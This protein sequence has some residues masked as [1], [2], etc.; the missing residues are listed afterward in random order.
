MNNM[1]S[2]SKPVRVR[3][4]SQ[5]RR[6][7]LIIGD[8]AVAVLSL[9]IA[10]FFWA[11]PDWLNF[12]L[13]FI[14][15]RIPWWYYFLPLVWMLLL[16]ELYDVRRASRQREVIRG[17]G[18]AAIISLG[19]YLLVYFTSEPSSLPRRGVATFIL[20]NAVLTFL[21]RILYIR[22]FTA[23]LFM[24]RVL[25]VGAGRSGETLANVVKDLSPPPFILAGF[26]DDD[27]DK[28]GSEI[29]GY[30]VLLPPKT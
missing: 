20:V 2:V 18:I 25:I 24:R 6:L 13:T 29:Q 16:T 17:I 23:R 15:E 8:L 14:Q 5:E 10:I 21:W 1:K 19:L 28:I 22:I 11:Q 12:S 7:I 27:L 4:R 26:I 9:M 30:H 3:L